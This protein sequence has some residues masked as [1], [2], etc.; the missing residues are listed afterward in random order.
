[1]AIDCDDKWVDKVPFIEFAINLSVDM[2][3]SKMP[4]G[5]CCG[6]NVWTVA[7]QLDGMHRVEAA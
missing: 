1:M 5:L 6:E 3:T 4:L 2:S 7:D